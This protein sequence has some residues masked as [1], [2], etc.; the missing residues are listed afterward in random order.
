MKRMASSEQ[1]EE[2]VRPSVVQFRG[3]ADRYIH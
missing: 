3:E 1:T 2:E